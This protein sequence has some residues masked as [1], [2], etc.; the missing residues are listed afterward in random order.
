MRVGNSKTV[1]FLGALERKVRR[2]LMDFEVPPS[3]TLSFHPQELSWDLGGR[4]GGGLGAGTTLHPAPGRLLGDRREESRE[5]SF[6]Q[7]WTKLYT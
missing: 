1:L 5:H 7:A 3:P 6:A 4:R 2:R